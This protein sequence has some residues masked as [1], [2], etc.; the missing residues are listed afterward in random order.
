ML[1]VPVRA[2]QARRPKQLWQMA[3]SVAEQEQV[4][5]QVA[6]ANYLPACNLRHNSASYGAHQHTDIHASS[7]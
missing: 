1:H 2:Q 6:K 7:D 4:G 3:A 5:A